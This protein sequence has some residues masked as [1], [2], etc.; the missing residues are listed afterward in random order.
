MG[1]VALAGTGIVKLLRGLTVTVGDALVWF[2]VLALV[3]VCV[4]LVTT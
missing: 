4:G 3:V 1:R 2:A